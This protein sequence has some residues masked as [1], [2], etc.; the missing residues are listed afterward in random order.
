M[1][2]LVIMQSDVWGTISYQ[3][4]VTHITGCV[5]TKKR[6]PRKNSL[7]LLIR[8]QN[9]IQVRGN[10]VRWLPRKSAQH[11]KLNSP[12][13]VG[14]WYVEHEDRISRQARKHSQIFAPCRSDQHFGRSDGG[15][16]IFWLG[17]GPSSTIHAM[18]RPQLKCTSKWQCI[19]HTPAAH[20]D[21]CTSN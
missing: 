10:K 4:A 20:M 5:H 12:D 17:S 2:D 9:G 15:G 8:I 18:E 13:Q 11:Y 14:S 3:E 1:Y 16:N 19:S 7:S 6:C 21:G